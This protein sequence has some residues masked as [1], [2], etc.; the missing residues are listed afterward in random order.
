MGEHPEERY[1][2][3]LLIQVE[4]KPQE[5]TPFEKRIPLFGPPVPKVSQPPPSKPFVSDR[6]KPRFTK[7][8]I[9]VM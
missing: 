5:L 9:H 3:D 4:G 2:Q 1:R 8:S 6:I 7:V